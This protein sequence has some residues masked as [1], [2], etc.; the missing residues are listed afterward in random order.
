MAPNEGRIKAGIIIAALLTVY[1]LY[2]TVIRF[3]GYEF[4]PDSIETY[5]LG[6]IFALLGALLCLSLLWGEARRK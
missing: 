5:F 2:M 6:T 1:R 3:L 4:T